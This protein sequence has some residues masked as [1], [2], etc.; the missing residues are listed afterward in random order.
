MVGA[1]TERGKVHEEPQGRQGALVQDFGLPLIPHGKM[2][3][4]VTG[5]PDS[6][7]R[8]LQLPFPSVLWA[9]CYSQELGTHDVD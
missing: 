1:D 7:R 5:A 6:M 8:R 4:P 2:G 3:T 9:S